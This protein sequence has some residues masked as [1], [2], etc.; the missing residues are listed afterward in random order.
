MPANDIFHS[1]VKNALIKEGW[2]ITHDPLSLRYGKTDFYIDL[3]AEKI[4][5]AE[6]EGKKI[7]VE[8]KS[9][10]ND[11]VTYEFHAA[12]GQFTNY[13]YVLEE[14]DPD[15][16]LYMA[17]PTHIYDSFFQSQF[18]QMV[19]RKSGIKIIAYNSEEEEIE[20][21]ID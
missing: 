20:K 18:G 6:K 4:L 1:V 15:R 8:I 9:F 5:A 12:L 16:I 10:L 2:K 3:G 11:S 19:V 13:R 17:V 14:I 7:A 21:W